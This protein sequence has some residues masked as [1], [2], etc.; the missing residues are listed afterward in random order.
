MFTDTATDPGINFEPYYP[1][2]VSYEMPGL[3][4]YGGA[5][6]GNAA[7]GAGSGSGGNAGSGSGT[8]AA[9]ASATRAATTLATSARTSFSLP[10]RVISSTAGAPVASNV[11]GKGK[12]CRLRR[13]GLKNGPLA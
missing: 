10:N 2:V 6:G 4:V 5:A 8:T 9:P 13:R 3:A 11:P 7:P 1:P 12:N